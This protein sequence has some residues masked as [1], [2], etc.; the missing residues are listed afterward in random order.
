[1]DLKFCREVRCNEFENKIKKFQNQQP[2]WIFS[3]KIG[4]KFQNGLSASPAKMTNGTSLKLPNFFM[5]SSSLYQYELLCKIS[6]QMEQYFS[7]YGGLK[8]QPFCVLSGQ[9]GTH[10]RHGCL[11]HI[12]GLK[13]LNMI[14][15]QNFRNSQKISAM[16]VSGWNSAGKNSIGGHYVPP[17]PG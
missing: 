16:Q 6:A 13:F 11:D 14:Q 4:R 17:S 5:Q 15:K 10:S 8:F 3:A 12:F 2:F 7:F 9:G 1:M